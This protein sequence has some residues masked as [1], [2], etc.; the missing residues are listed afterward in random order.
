VR[1]EG[2]VPN[3]KHGDN[4]L[5]DLTVHGAHPFPRDI[6]AL[7][8]R[9]D[10]LGRRPDRWPLGEHWPFSPREFEW[11]RGHDL[12]GAR[13]DLARLIAMLETGRGDEVLIDHRTGRP[14]G[15]AGPDAAAEPP[16]P[17]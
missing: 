8:L 13:R 2:T 10:A 14:F 5:S 9:V 11:A 12:E 3:G 4:P 16:A 1:T 7:L 6:E 15:A 17:E